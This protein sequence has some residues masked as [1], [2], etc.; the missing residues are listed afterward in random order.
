MARRLCRAADIRRV[1]VDLLDRVEHVLWVG[2]LRHGISL[3]IDPVANERII[4]TK[5]FQQLDHLHR[6]LLTQKRQFQDELL[7]EPGDNRYAGIAEDQ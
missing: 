4:S 7:A 1:S 3:L 5:L 6:L 2:R